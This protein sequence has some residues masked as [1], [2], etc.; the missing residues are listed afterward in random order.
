MQKMQ[1]NFYLG[2][3]QASVIALENVSPAETI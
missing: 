2:F 3:G 1:L